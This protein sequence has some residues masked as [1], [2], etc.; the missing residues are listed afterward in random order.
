MTTAL[1]I[2]DM[3][4][5]T[6]HADGAYASFGAAA[7]AAS[8]NVIANVG[9]VLGAAR[10]AGV[11][12][13]HTRIV[14]HP[15]AGLGGANAPIFRMLAP[16]TFKLGSWGAAIVDELTP[17][18][19]EVV[20]DRIRMNAFG[21]TSLDIMLRNLGVTKL[22]VAGAW[23]NMAVEHTVREAADHGYEV[24]IV[25]DATSSLSDEWQQAAL[26]YALTNI[27]TIANTAETAASFQS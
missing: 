1:L 7:H 5:D 26:G 21:G 25:S 17:V 11:P 23:T 14:V 16:D 6:V 19:G 10:G 12:V 3:Q 18:D 2:I 8:Q 24:T 20:L 4:N 27:A 15:V 22:V 13:F 9:T